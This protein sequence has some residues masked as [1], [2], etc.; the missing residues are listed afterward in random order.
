MFGRKVNDRENNN[1]EYKTLMRSMKRVSI[2]KGS[3]L[4]S[5][6]RE[7]RMNII[8]SRFIHTFTIASN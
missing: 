5:K 7:E 8:I 6:H 1:D 4:Q 2:V 3:S